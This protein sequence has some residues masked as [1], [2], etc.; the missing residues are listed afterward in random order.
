M[1]FDH[2]FQY[3]SYEVTKKVKEMS[4]QISMSRIGNSLDNREA[5]YFFSCLKGEYLNRINTQKMKLKEIYKHIQWY[6]S[7][8][9]NHKIQKVLNL[10]TPAWA[11]V[12]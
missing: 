8:Y 9:N 3:S 1:H 12:N 7:W 6:I 11:S 4:S 5:E 10:K 2:G